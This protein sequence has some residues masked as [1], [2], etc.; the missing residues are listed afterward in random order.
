MSDM[1]EMSAESHGKH[2]DVL[3]GLAI[4]FLEMQKLISDFTSRGN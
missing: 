4:S 2:D 1:T 3:E